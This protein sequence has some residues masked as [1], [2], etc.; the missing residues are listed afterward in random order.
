MNLIKIAL[1]IVLILAT[2]LTLRLIGVFGPIDAFAYYNRGLAYADKGDYDKAI[3]D[4]TKAV[5]LDPKLAGA[6]NGR[7]NA[8]YDKGAFDNTIAD[9]NSAIQLTPK[10]AVLYYNRGNAYLKLGDFTN[11]ESDLNKAKELGYK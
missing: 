6:Y 5:E 4:Y 8:F 9:Y 11:A 7:G 1:G 10:W 2:L 3:S